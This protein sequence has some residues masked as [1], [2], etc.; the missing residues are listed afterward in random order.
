M[1]HFFTIFLILTVVCCNSLQASVTPLFICNST[2]GALF[3][4]E[5]SRHH[6]AGGLTDRP[7]LSFYTIPDTALAQW[8]DSN[9]ADLIVNDD[10]LDLTRASEI[11]EMRI[12]WDGV[13]N[14]PEGYLFQ[15]ITNLDGLQHFINL[16]NF[17]SNARLQNVPNLSGLQFLESFIATNANLSFNQRLAL[18]GL[19]LTTLTINNTNFKFTSQKPF[20]E[21]FDINITMYPTG[22]EVVIK[23][24]SLRDIHDQS[25]FHWYKNGELIQSDKADSLVLTNFDRSDCGHIFSACLQSSV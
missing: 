22:S 13:T 16:Q 10:Q 8:L 5:Y 21:P 12:E 14:G 7:A 3:G 6:T 9:F 4:N 15:R 1:R 19:A 18:E 25:I 2:A 17:V 24:A 11:T 23:N 20:P